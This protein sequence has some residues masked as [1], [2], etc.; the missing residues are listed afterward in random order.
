MELHT[1]L[2]EDVKANGIIYLKDSSVTIEDVE[3]YGTP[4]QPFF[5]NWAFN[6]RD[7]FALAD[8][9][10]KIPA[11]TDFLITHCSAADMLDKCTDG[12]VGSPE[13][14]R[15]LKRICPE[16]HLFGHIHEGYGTREQNGVTYI[17]ASQCDE[18]YNCS[19]KPIVVEI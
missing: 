1:F 4:Y 7:P 5:C 17:N 14:Q 13:L 2:E 15:A 18:H 3:F 11:S 19:N 9:Y 6:I 12:H 16:Y 10:A 8:I